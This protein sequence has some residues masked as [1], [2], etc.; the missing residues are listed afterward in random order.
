MALDSEAKR[1]SMLQIAGGPSYYPFVFNPDT[2]GVVAIERATLL[3]LYGGIPLTETVVAPPATAVDNGGGGGKRVIWSP[4]AWLARFDK[5]AE[6][7]KKRPPRLPPTPIEP[8]L[9][10]EHIARLHQVRVKLLNQRTQTDMVLRVLTQLD[11]RI[12]QLETDDVA[13]V[14]LLLL[15]LE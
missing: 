11:E 14:L 5:V 8:D 4:E 1:W 13:A 6:R 3:K 15:T 7:S 2:S 9:L 10:P 12:A